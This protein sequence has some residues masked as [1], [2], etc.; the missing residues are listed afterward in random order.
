MEKLLET[1]IRSSGLVHNWSIIGFCGES[2][3]HHT[4]WRFC[5]TV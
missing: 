1:R 4:C 3:M 5:M 2:R